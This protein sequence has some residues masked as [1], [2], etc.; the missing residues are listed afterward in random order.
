MVINEQV[1]KAEPDQDETVNEVFHYELERYE[2]ALLDT[3][4]PQ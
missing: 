1:R 4:S 3:P 2:N